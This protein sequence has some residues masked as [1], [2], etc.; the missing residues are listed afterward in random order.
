MH[1]EE[2]V[3]GQRFDLGARD[4][5]R[6]EI[7]DFAARHDW[8]PFH[9]DA[10][11]ATQSPFGGLIASGFQTLLIAFELILEAELWHGTGMGSPG[12]DRIRWHA[13]VRP[14][15]RLQVSAEITA[16]RR[17]KTRPDRGTITLTVGVTGRA[18]VMLMSFD[19]MA[20]VACRESEPSA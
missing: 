4:I 20:I 9:L 19:L 17:S 6:E 12:M 18:Q 14:G 16:V 7:V 11:A 3:V 13:P 2:F 10:E 15:E 8:Q 1:F 5:S